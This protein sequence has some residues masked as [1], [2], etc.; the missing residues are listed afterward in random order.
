M[1]L[2]LDKMSDKTSDRLFD[3]L[4]KSSVSLLL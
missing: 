3:R 2:M 1:V 4:L